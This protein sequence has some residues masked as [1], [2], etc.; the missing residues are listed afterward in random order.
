VKFT[1]TPGEQAAPLSTETVHTPHAVVTYPSTLEILEHEGADLVL[2]YREAFAAFR[3]NVVLTSVASTAPLVDASTIALQAAPAQHPSAQIHACD[4]WGT[5]DA[6]HA[7]TGRRIVFTYHAEDGLDV[8]VMKWVW[9]TGAHHVHL[10]ASFLPSQADVVQPTVEWMA[11]TLALTADAAAVEAAA[12]AVG[13]APTDA[14]LSERAGF[15]LE[16]LTRIPPL[17]FHSRAPL[18]TNAALQLLLTSTERT[19][20]RAAHGS[21]SRRDR[22]SAEAQQLIAANYVDAQGRVTDQGAEAAEALAGRRTVALVTARRGARTE[23][24]VAYAGSRG[25]LV[26]HTPSLSEQPNPDASAAKHTMYVAADQVP[27]MIA[28]W[29]GLRPA[30]AF[31]DVDER[32]DAAELDA[33]LADES[34]T[35]W[36]VRDGL[37]DGDLVVAVTPDRGLLGL[38]APDSG[39]HPVQAMPSGAVFERILAGC[40]RAFS[41]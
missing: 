15:P 4:V 37:G 5:A 23:M 8:L 32:I 29:L 35:Q 38:G 25:A 27:A 24:L 41:L 7:P 21:L 20:F 22:G 19:G 30:W 3:P 6:D 1:M 16:D 17:R 14:T 40:D 2:A 31:S 39:S 13:D 11:R 12:V 36:L 9:A 33:R 26:L 18:L 10:S 34:W 28:A